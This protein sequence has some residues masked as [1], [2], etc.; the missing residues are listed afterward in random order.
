MRNF[1]TIV[2]LAV[3]SLFPAKAGDYAPTSTWPYVYEDFVG[4]EL[5][6]RDGQKRSG[7]FNIALTDSKLHF[8]EGDMVQ[9]ARTFDIDRVGIGEDI[10]VN[11]GGKLFKVLSKSDK[12]LVV[13]GS[14]IDYAKLNSS[15][16]AYGASTA[17][18]SVQAL[19]S[20]EGFGGAHTNMNH[21]ALKNS[22][23]E[24]KSLPLIVRKYVVID[25][26][27]V[28]ASKRDVLALAER[29]GYK[30]EVS[31]FI[32]TNKI[33]WKSTTSLQQL[34]DYLVS[35]ETYE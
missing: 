25:G 32:K 6:F 17:S 4:G 13:E 27:P 23:E 31:S 22:K 5:V 18:V 9:E 3:L 2:A 33:K 10:Y 24:G 14:E 16:G 8:I 26:L 7:L 11:L 29:K 30:S 34:A 15:E 19:S 1:V 20:L 28:F 35:I 12:A 21:M